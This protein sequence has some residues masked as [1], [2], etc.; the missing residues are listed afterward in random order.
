M[1]GPRLPLPWFSA[2]RVVLWGAVGHRQAP[3][4]IGGAVLVLVALHELVLLWQRIP[5]WIPLST[6]GLTQIRR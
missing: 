2:P 3:V 5:G 1:P 4:V 6:G